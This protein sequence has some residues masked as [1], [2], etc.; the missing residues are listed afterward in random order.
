M[1]PNEVTEAASAK[2]L[3]KRRGEEGC[4]VQRAAGRQ[5]WEGSLTK[6]EGTEREAGGPRGT[7]AGTGRDA[8]FQCALRPRSG[9]YQN[10]CGDAL[11]SSRLFSVRFHHPAPPSSLFS[12]QLSFWR[13]S[14]LSCH[15]LLN[16]WILFLP[17]ALQQRCFHQGHHASTDKL[18]ADILA[19]VLLL[20]L[21]LV[22]LYH[23][24]S[25]PNSD[26]SSSA[27]QSSCPDKP[28]EEFPLKPLQVCPRESLTYVRFYYLSVKVFSFRLDECNSL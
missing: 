2:G 12:S 18:S 11:L 21:F 15:A 9:R 1:G 16:P 8:G 13:G 27:Y 25:F 4:E 10:G 5:R 17:L 22:N 14:F 24:L 26:A 20:S 28:V 23:T 19:L 7:G 6:A 3:G